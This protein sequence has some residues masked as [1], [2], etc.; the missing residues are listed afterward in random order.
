[1]SEATLDY[2]NDVWTEPMV[3]PG[4]RDL[5][6]RMRDGG[7]WNQIHSDRQYDSNDVCCGCDDCVAMALM[8]I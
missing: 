5:E 2:A 4:N 3:S 1:M 8:M 7:H 6:L